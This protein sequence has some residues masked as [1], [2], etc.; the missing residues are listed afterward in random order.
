MNQNLS[1]HYLLCGVAT[2]WVLPGCVVGEPHPAARSAAKTTRIPTSLAADAASGPLTIDRAVRLALAHNP[3]LRASGARRDAAAGRAVQ[4]RVWQ[5]PDLELS[6]EDVPVNSS[7]M[8]QSKKMLGIAQTVPFPGK[9]RL[10]SA[11][12]DADAQAGQAAWRLHQAQLARDVKIEFYRVLAAEQSAQVTADLVG[13]A[14]SSA[15]AAKKRTDAGDTALQEQLRAELQMEQATTE[16]VEA[17]RKV[18]EARQAFALLLGLPAL[19]ATPLVGT[20]DDAPESDALLGVPSGWLAG[21]PAMVTAQ[22][23]CRLA[24]ATVHRAEINH[25]PDPKVALEGGRDEAADEN[26]VTLRLSIPLPI[27]D[28]SKGRIAESRAG[29][30]EAAAELAATEQQLLAEWHTAVTRYKVAAS[31]VAA[32]RERMLPKSEEALSLVRVG[33]E[34]GKFGFIDLLDTQRMTAEVRL[35]YQKKRFELNAA[36]A[37]LESFLTPVPTP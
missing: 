36:R 35:A 23:K 5:N 24:A 13:L 34:Q 17:Q 33:Y 10:D 3:D 9:K 14:E 28:R 26:I 30:A 32:H 8:S 21:H 37:E 19:R 4:A 7:R 31:Q 18:T 6:A 2:L 16:Q 1:I 25:L 11:I 27:F 20:P 12:G 15:E 22:A 29:V